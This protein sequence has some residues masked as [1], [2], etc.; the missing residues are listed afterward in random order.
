MKTNLL[1]LKMFNSK[2]FGWEDYNQFIAL[3]LVKNM[4]VSPNSIRVLKELFIVS[5]P[6]SR[7]FAGLKND[8]SPD[9]LRILCYI[10]S[11][12]L[13]SIVYYIYTKMA[14]LKKLSGGDIGG[15]SPC[16][17]FHKSLIIIVDN[18]KTLWHG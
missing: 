13:F 8:F 14:P 4:V 11:L 6:Y 9:H 3:S 18:S 12:V 7:H 16:F 1:K 17:S 10:S 15:Q 2:D 5:G